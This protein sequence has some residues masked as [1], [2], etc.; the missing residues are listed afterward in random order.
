MYSVDNPPGLGTDATVEGMSWAVAEATQAGDWGLAAQLT[1]TI[2]ALKGAK[3][4]KGFGKGKPGKGSGAAPAAAGKGGTHTFDGICNHCGHY[5]HRLSEC[6]KRDAELGKTG[7]GKGGPKGKAGGKNGA[8]GGKGPA[9]APLAEVAAADGWTGDLLDGAIAEAAAGIDEW[10]FDT[11]ICSLTAATYEQ[12][13]GAPA[14]KGTRK[15]YPAGPASDKTVTITGAA[16]SASSRLAQTWYGAKSVQPFSRQSSGKTAG[17][18]ASARLAQHE[19][20]LERPYRTFAGGVAAE[21]AGATR[22]TKT[23]NR[24]ASVSYTPL[25]LPTNREVLM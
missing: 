12:N 6:R 9:A 24:C 13:A 3:G 18:S 11:A 21:L 8:T 25:T 7:G 4:R 17:A 23:P 20:L 16:A 19:T 1:D 22:E 5:G 15:T 14:I 10:D 2:F